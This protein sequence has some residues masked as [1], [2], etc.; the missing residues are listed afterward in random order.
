MGTDLGEGGEGCCADGAIWGWGRVAK[1]SLGCRI[2]SHL[3]A[4]NAQQRWEENGV[5]KVLHFV[6]FVTSGIKRET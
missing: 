5:E 6:T 1:K 3:V 2:L 4:P